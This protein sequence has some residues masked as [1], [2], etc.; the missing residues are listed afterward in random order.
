MRM[1][2][3]RSLQVAAGEPKGPVT[4]KVFFDIEIGGNKAGRILI[5]LYGAACQHCTCSVD[6][7]KGRGGG[8]EGLTLGADVR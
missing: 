1:A 7:L 8:E 2:G 5:G 3:R 6:G 4:E